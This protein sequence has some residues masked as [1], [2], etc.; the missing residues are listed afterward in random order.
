MP[1]GIPSLASP[2]GNDPAGSRHIDTHCERHPV[3]G[4][5]AIDKSIPLNTWDMTSRCWR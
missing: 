1:M 3:R 2:I 5:L 4:F